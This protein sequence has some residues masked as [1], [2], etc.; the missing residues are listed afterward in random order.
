M[1]RGITVEIINDLVGLFISKRHAIDTF[2]A[3]VEKHF[4]NNPELVIDGRNVVH[5]TKSR[6]KDEDHLREKIRRK[7]S[8]GRHINADNFFSEITDLAGV[9]VLLLYQEDFS[10]VDR[11]IR[12]KINDLGDWI[13]AEEPKAYTW[14]PES[15]AYFEGLGV[16]PELKSSSYTSVHYLIRPHERSPVRCEIQVRTLFEEIWG[17]VDH[18]LNY[19]KP[20]GNPALS[21]QIKVLSKIVGA[22]SRLL[23]SIHRVNT[24][25]KDG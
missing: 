5:S 3:G 18:H 25:V 21:E 20:T 24:A 1:G 23:D 19:P 11:V 9:R 4:T 6:V 7:I 15:T 22:G 8:D 12:S 2:R 17:E 10:I 16:R 13:F 14:D